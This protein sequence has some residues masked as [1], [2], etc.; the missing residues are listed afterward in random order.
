MTE[1]QILRNAKACVQLLAKG[2]D[3]LTKAPV[4]E[5]DV[6]RKTAVSKYLYFIADILEKDILA[7]QQ[8]QD[9]ISN[10]FFVSQER[11]DRFYP[12]EE[13]LTITP[14]AKIIN[15]DIA[16]DE[17]GFIPSSAI[18][19]WLESKKLLVR[20]VKDN[21]FRRQATEEAADYGITNRY[22][23]SGNFKAVIYD[24]QAQQWI[25]DSIEE[26][27]DFCMQNAELF[28][29]PEKKFIPP[30]ATL[31]EPKRQ[32]KLERQE[33]QLTPE[34]KKSLCSFAEEAKISEITGYLNSLIDREQVKPLKNGIISGWLF[35]EGLLKKS[36]RGKEMIPTEEGYHI[37]IFCKN[38]IRNQQEFQI[39][40]YTRQ[41]QEYIFTR[42]EDLIEFNLLEN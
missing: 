1:L 15:G 39:N 17:D 22:N 30:L 12:S 14:L 41:A 4:S 5:D 37:G 28:P 9:T 20:Y 24:A 11:I 19:C 10:R 29:R 25:F 42:I 35:S 21:S 18:S 34:Q 8:K 32:E 16:P 31:A 33:F 6:V 23:S 26:I 13:P 38:Y 7:E 40:I 36:G 3:P 2:I 27:S